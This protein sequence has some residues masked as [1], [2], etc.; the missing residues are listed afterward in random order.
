MVSSTA[1]KPPEVG[2]AVQVRNR[3]ATIRAVEAYDSRTASGRLHVVDV[4]YLD[5]WRYPESEQLLWEVEAT[6]KVLGTT[7]LPGVDAN[8]PDSPKALQ[9]FVNA[10][11]WT[12]LNRLREGEDIKDEPLLGVWNSAIQVHAYQLEPVLKALAMPRV[13][14][15]LADGVGLGK[16]IQAGLVLEELL[17]RRRIRRILVVCPAMLQRQ[18]KYELRRK[19]NLD[20][21]VIDSDSTFELR[22]RLGIDTNPWKAF[23]RTITSMDY[24]RMPDVLGQFLQASGAGSDSQ[25]GGIGTSAH[26]PWDLLIVD[27]CHHFAPQNGGR[28]SQRTRMLREIRFLFEHRIFASATPHNGKTVC[29]TGLLE[30]LDPIRF[31]MTTEMDTK[32]R[33]NLSEVRIRRL[34]D[35]INQQSIRPLFA[36]QLPPV[37]LKLVLSPQETALYAALREYRRRGEAALGSATTD[38]RWLGHFIY[39]LLTKRLLSCPF[40]FAR[41][42][43]RHIESEA[44]TEGASLFDMARVSAERAE[45]QSK[46]DDE[47]SLLEEDAARHTGAWFRS[48]GKTTEELQRRVSQ[49]LEA[50]GLDRKAVEDPGKLKSLALKPDSKLDALVRWVKDHLFS[51]GKLRDDERLILF[52]EYKETLF[53]LEQRFLQEGFDKNTLR[54]LFGGMNLDS[55]EAVKSEFEDRNASVRLLLATDAASEGI[56]MQEEC[57]WIVHYDIPWSPS[58]LQ[59]RNGR[60]SRHG[61]LRD[62]SVHY[63]CCDQEEDMN[64]L[65]RVAQKV[66]QVRHDLGSVEKIFDAAI[67]RHFQGKPTS[68]EQINLFVDEEIRR[69]PEKTELGQTAGRDL[70]DLNR[71]ARELLESTDARLGISPEALVEIL[72]AAIAV[73]GQGSLEEITDRPGFYRLRPP[74]RWEGLARQTLTVGSR[75]DR[76]E[77]IFDSAVVEDEVQGRRVLRLQKHQALMRLAHPIMRQAM[78]ILCRQLHDPTAHDP[79]FRWSVAALHRSGF[80]ALLV[81]YYTITAINELREPLHDELVSRVFRVVGERLEPVEQDFERDVLRSEFLPIK[82][83]SHRDDWV[84]A[85]RGRWF[86]HGK[87]IEAYLGEQESALKDVMQTRADSTLKREGD[88]A[89]ES[90][91]YRL[92]ELQDRSREQELEKLVK[93]L[94]REKS[95][96]DQPMLFEEFRED[97]KLKL[98]EIEEQMTVLR[99]DVDRTRDQL[100]RERDNRLNIVLPKRFRVREVRVLPL[101]LT[102]LVPATAEDLRS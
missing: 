23:P 91:R 2:Q 49:A 12:R 88:A 72:R 100:S 38:E 9:A 81:F 97:S 59:Q 64:F 22:R 44:E 89:K 80:D 67:Q 78:S 53:Y 30:L 50:M 27:E 98:Q 69:S 29:F 24:L 102:Y 74:P 75:T 41:T 8:R 4:E 42:W 79:I 55:F 51:D 56:N 21:E 26:A 90:Y 57:R 14:L 17:L 66:E 47:R 63:F 71:R 28:A 54:L 31:Q 20:F 11:R 87:A 96:L 16:T 94:V 15:L 34:K 95:D 6:A 45:E 37:E 13:S 32:D 65:F 25:A 18:W 101:A 84:K 73:E 36:E 83:S 82:S 40:A 70:A 3:L 7:S 39:S 19:F 1:P 33:S 10:H 62:V 92:K 85:F 61:Q 58:K 68:I 35:D 5:D 52:T 99:Q 76:M 48:Q 77:L 93:Q 60:V 86:P 46:S 43:W